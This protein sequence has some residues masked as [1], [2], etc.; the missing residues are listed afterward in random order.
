MKN[1][2]GLN[3]YDILQ[4]PFEASSAEIEQAHKEALSVYG[5]DALATYCLFSEDERENIL[6][7]IEKAYLTLVDEDKR[8]AY[9]DELAASGQFNETIIAKGQ[10]KLSHPSLSSYL[11]RERHL[12]DPNSGMQSTENHLYSR[13]IMQLIDSY[14]KDIELVKKD[15]QGIKNRHKLLWMKEKLQN[16]RISCELEPKLLTIL[17]EIEK[18]SLRRRRKISVIIIT[19]TLFAVGGFIVQ[20][21]TNAIM[22]PGFNIPY[23]VLLMG[24]FGC[25][26]SMWLRLPNIRSEQSLQYDLTVWFIICPPVAVIAAG[27]SFGIAQFLTSVFQIDLS[28]ESW[29]FWILAFVVGFV[30]WVYFYERL[31]GGFVNRGRTKKQRPS[32]IT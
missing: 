4:V 25:L 18:S 12:T 11:Q 19:Y 14:K 2:N 24:L 10:I 6:S 27:I 15:R 16:M 23:S 29:I 26:L 8:S 30:N 13:E 20:T 21:A 17:T 1:L 3:Y 9:N 31:M 32:E 5:E 28:D 7:L 22:L